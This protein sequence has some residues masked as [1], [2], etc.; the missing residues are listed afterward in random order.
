MGISIKQMHLRILICFIIVIACT[1][2]VSSQTQDSISKRVLLDSL[3]YVNKETVPPYPYQTQWDS[4]QVL[5]AEGP[6]IEVYVVENSGQKIRGWNRKQWLAYWQSRLPEGFF[7]VFSI[8]VAWNGQITQVKLQVY[9]GDIGQVDLVS[10]AKQLR[11]T[12]P[13]YPVYP[14]ESIPAPD[15]GIFSVPIF[16]KKSHRSN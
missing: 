4:L 14:G 13:I 10:I 3:L 9:Q 11:A 1:S 12:S 7:A 2:S 15:P 16:G 6:V 8:W 5:K